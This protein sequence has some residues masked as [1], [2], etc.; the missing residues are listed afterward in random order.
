MPMPPV[1][2]PPLNLKVPLPIMVSAP[3]LD[4][5]MRVAKFGVVNKEI[6]F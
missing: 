6:S 2:P 3:D 1:P 4:A 5:G